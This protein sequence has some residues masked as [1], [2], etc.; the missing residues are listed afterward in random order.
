MLNQQSLTR[1]SSCIFTDTKMCSPPVSVKKK[2][3][4][5]EMYIIIPSP[6]KEKK[7]SVC[8]CLGLP[9][10]QMV[11]NLP[12]MQETRVQSLCREDPLEKEMAIHSSILAWRIPGK[13][14]WWATVCEVTK[15]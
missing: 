13:G 6:L 15:N 10:A 1:Q 7:K 9:V 8:V 14:A 5:T 4:R 11:K 12:A 3:C 2:S